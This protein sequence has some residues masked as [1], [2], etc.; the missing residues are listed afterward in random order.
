M[1][2]SIAIAVAGVGRMGRWHLEKAKSHP[3]V[4]VVGL[5]DADANRSAEVA[6]ITGVRAFDD[7]DRL[8][9]EADAVVVAAATAAHYPLALAALEAGRHVLVEKPIAKTLGEA[10]ALAAVAARFGVRLHVGFLERFRLAGRYREIVQSSI[11]YVEADRLTVGFPRESG[12]DVINDL[13]THDLDLLQWLTGCDD[14][15]AA[16][17]VD[18]EG[19]WG[20]VSAS[21]ALTL[22]NGTRARLSASWVAHAPRRTLRVATETHWHEFD[23]LSDRVASRRRGEDWTVEPIGLI[24]ALAAQI[25]DFVGAIQGE[26][27]VGA[28]AEDGLWTLRAAEVI[29]L[30]ADRGPD[31][32]Q[33][34]ATF[35]PRSVTLERQR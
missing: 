4:R 24:D 25:D 21:A 14:V 33:P 16:A 32:S 7:Y 19:P 3:A 20:P 5:Y 8:I 27:A 6:S 35:D 2:T 29:R 17:I 15:E 12:T 34:L 22:S 23:F 9:A 28:S 31:R 11:R 18:E 26:M 30:A 1:K 13:M 10:E